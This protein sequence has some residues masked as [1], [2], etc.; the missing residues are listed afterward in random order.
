V[1]VAARSRIATGLDL[2][3]SCSETSTVKKR[4]RMRGVVTLL[5]PQWSWERRNVGCE[6]EN[7]EE[8]EAAKGY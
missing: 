4:V 3:V 1:P 6:N 8:W 5:Q 7:K 2:V